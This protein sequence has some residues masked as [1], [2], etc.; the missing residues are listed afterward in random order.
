VDEIQK[1]AQINIVEHYRWTGKK[2]TALYPQ[3]V[4]ILGRSGTAAE[5]SSIQ[6]VSG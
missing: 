4:D 5:S 1:E 6:P 2:H 3:M